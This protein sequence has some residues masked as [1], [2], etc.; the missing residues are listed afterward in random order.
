MT[1]IVSREG[2]SCR[3]VRVRVF[4][5]ALAHASLPG[6]LRSRMCQ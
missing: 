1:G 6:G 4:M 2:V 5:R 3:S